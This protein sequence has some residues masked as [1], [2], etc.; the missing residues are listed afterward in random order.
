MYIV[1]RHCGRQNVDYLLSLNNPW[2]TV[3]MGAKSK[4]LTFPDVESARAA[5]RKARRACMG[6]N[7]RHQV[8]ARMDFRPTQIH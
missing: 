2:G 4:A 3:C 7:G 1:T 8:R 6:W 5:A